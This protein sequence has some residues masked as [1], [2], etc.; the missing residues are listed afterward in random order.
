M[1]SRLRLATDG[2]EARYYDEN[3]RRLR[4]HLPAMGTKVP[5]DVQVDAQI[6]DGSPER[7]PVPAD[8]HDGRRV[9]LL[10]REHCRLSFWLPKPITG[11]SSRN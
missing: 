7:D 11:K 6:L 3:R 9:S 10:P 8:V 4:Y 1:T 2:Q 5:S